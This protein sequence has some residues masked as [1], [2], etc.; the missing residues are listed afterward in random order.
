MHG[1]IRNVLKRDDLKLF[2]MLESIR[3]EEEPYNSIY[4]MLER[5]RFRKNRNDATHNKN[6][7]REEILDVREVLMDNYGVFDEINNLLS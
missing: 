2:E 7:K 6:I 4:D 1:Y 5:K 3:G